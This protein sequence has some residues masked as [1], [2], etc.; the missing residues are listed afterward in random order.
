MKIGAYINFL[1]KKSRIKEIFKSLYK[2]W[3]L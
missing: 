2:K 1:K 3:I